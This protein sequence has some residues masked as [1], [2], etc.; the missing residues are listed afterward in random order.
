M[1]EEDLPT[2]TEFLSREA[3]EAPV[4]DVALLGK[5]VGELVAVLEMHISRDAVAIR[6][7]VVAHDLRKKRIGRFMID[8]LHSLASKIDR[9]RLV[10]QCEAPA[11]FLQRVG[12]TPEED[13]MVRR[14]AR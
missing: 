4:P 6:G 8:E 3:P 5:L 11:G 14:V 12:F 7:L 10:V 9:D 1:E 2:V 13:G